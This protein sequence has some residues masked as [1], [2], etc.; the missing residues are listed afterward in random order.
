MNPDERCR[1]LVENSIARLG[2]SAQKLR[3]IL[4]SHGH[5]DHF[6]NA[7]YFQKQYGTRIY[8]SEI[9]YDYMVSRSGAHL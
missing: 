7:E 8:M 6:G 4:I 3:A 5:G 2:E 1:K 9:D